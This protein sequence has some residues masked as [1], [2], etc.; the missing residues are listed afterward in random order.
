MAGD[1]ARPRR[2][3]ESSD[4]GQQRRETSQADST[5]S[6]AGWCCASQRC[7]IAWVPARICSE[8]GRSSEGVDASGSV[9]RVTAL[10]PY[11]AE[12][13]SVHPSR[14]AK[15]FWKDFGV[16]HPNFV[17]ILTTAGAP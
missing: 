17:A 4:V 9:A 11:G 10:S 16:G 5:P 13:E 12:S 2:H 3:G 15:D 7:S 14:Y 6:R 1:V 8:R